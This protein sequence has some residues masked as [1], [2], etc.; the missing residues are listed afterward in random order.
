MITIGA[1]VITCTQRP[2]RCDN[3][4]QERHHAGVHTVEDIPEAALELQAAMRTAHRNMFQPV[5]KVRHCRSA[6]LPELGRTVDQSA[7][8]DAPPPAMNVSTALSI[9]GSGTLPNAKI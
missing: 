4:E 2:E 3:R 5:Q 1:A 8:G 9:T 6:L 7:K